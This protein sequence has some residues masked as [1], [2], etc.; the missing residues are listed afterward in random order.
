MILTI[1]TDET[2]GFCVEANI[3]I[4]SFV[5]SPMRSLQ[6]LGAALTVIGAHPSIG[7]IMPIMPIFKPQFCHSECKREVENTSSYSKCINPLISNAMNIKKAKFDF[8]DFL[9]QSILT[10]PNCLSCSPLACD[11]NCIK[12]ILLIS[13]TSVYLTKSSLQFHI[14]SYSQH[15]IPDHAYAEFYSFS[16]DFKLSIFDFL[17]NDTNIYCS[18][19]SISIFLFV[20]FAFSLAL[21]FNKIN[22][23]STKSF[24]CAVCIKENNIYCFTFL[25]CFSGIQ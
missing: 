5:Q 22:T 13:S 18:T 6:I 11:L 10:I 2:R 4:L 24:L 19:Y 15:T 23:F 12:Q 3:H 14:S 25:A 16:S 17:D 7:P 20:Y 21:V 8:R 1:S 9:Q